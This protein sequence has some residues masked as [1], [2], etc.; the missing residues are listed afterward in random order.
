M[1]FPAETW[2]YLDRTSADTVAKKSGVR[3][4]EGPLCTVD[5]YRQAGA[6]VLRPN[7]D[8]KI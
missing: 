3:T 7:I 2:R 6:D 1:E 4:A 8:H 5:E